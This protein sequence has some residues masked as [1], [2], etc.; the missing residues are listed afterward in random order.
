MKILPVCEVKWISNF[1]FLLNYVFNQNLKRTIIECADIFIF[2]SNKQNK[3]FQ[4]KSPH[5]L[6]H[7]YC[8]V[9]EMR[10]LKGQ[11]QGK[12]N[13]HRHCWLPCSQEASW[14]AK[15]FP[16]TITT[17]M[18]R[19]ALLVANDSSSTA[20]R[21]HLGALRSNFKTKVPPEGESFRFMMGSSLLSCGKKAVSFCLVF[22]EGQ[23]C[24][25]LFLWL[26]GR[27]SEREASLWGWDE[28]QSRAGKIRD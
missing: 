22:L 24:K 11:Q 3:H 17:M 18:A 6:V 14:A 12:A 16:Q 9:L 15:L 10:S 7:F 4:E 2:L 28:K 8:F 26:W 20:A 27:K 5:S 25:Q 23:V 1:N 19:G 21:M 13:K